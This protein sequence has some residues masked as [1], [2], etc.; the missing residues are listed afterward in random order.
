M[1]Y[2][3]EVEVGRAKCVR[4]SFEKVHMAYLYH[5]RGEMVHKITK[6]SSWIRGEALTASAP[7]PIELFC[8]CESAQ[9]NMKGV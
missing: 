9:H 2:W 7:S 1:D 6:T 4:R 8:L 3:Y 5:M